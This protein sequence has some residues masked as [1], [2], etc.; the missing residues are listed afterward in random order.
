MVSSLPL[1]S[2]QCHD[3]I[4]EKNINPDTLDFLYRL[5]FSDGKT[6]LNVLAEMLELCG[7]QSIF[8]FASLNIP[9]V[10]NTPLR[11]PIDSSGY[12]RRRTSQVGL[13][14]DFRKA[15]SETEG[16]CHSGHLRAEGPRY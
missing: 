1:V 10:R 6:L 16:K 2:V 3:M 13:H 7:S 8:H 5:E 11:F 15:R 4:E 12:L 14:P 9:P